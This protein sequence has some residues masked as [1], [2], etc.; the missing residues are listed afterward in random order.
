MLYIGSDTATIVGIACGVLGGITLFFLIAVVIYYCVK[1]RR[2]TSRSAD[3][4]GRS[5]DTG[6]GYEPLQLGELAKKTKST[7]KKTKRCK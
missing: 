6:K 5:S 4:A 7:G 2:Q 1:R 3:L